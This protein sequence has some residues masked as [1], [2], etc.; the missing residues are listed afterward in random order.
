MLTTCTPACCVLMPELVRMAGHICPGSRPVGRQSVGDGRCHTFPRIGPRYAV[1]F[2]RVPAKSALARIA[3]SGGC[4]RLTW[5]KGIRLLSAVC[6]VCPLATL[7]GCW[8]VHGVSFG[9]CCGL[10]GVWCVGGMLSSPA[11]CGHLL[12]GSFGRSAPFP[13]P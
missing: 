2:A 8:L 9:A 5:W 13:R 10:A 6:L 7:G 4:C 11:R 1:V 3:N 12:W